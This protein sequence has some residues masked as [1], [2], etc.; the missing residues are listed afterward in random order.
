LAPTRALHWLCSEWQVATVSWG[1]IFALA[2][3]ISF[4]A[5]RG[6]PA[7]RDDLWLHAA[8]CAQLERHQGPLASASA[9]A[10]SPCP[11]FALIVAALCSAPPPLPATHPRAQGWRRRQ[12]RGQRPLIKPPFALPVWRACRTRLGQVSRP[13]AQNKPQPNGATCWPPIGWPRSA[14]RKGRRNQR[15]RKPECRARARSAPTVGGRRPDQVEC[16]LNKI[17][18]RAQVCQ[19]EPAEAPGRSRLKL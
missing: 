2:E 19:L 5:V 1:F 16:N 7:S 13:L 18:K 8:R 11:A 3:S 4:P 15:E 14:W 9:L 17:F 12:T 10:L 6:R